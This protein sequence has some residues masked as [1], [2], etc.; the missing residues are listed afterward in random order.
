MADRPRLPVFN[1][2]V[3]FGEVGSGMGLEMDIELLKFGPDEPCSVVVCKG[4]T[5]GPDIESGARP[6]VPA[7]D[8][9]SALVS[10]FLPVGVEVWPAELI[11]WLLS[12]LC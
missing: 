3:G 10:I 11:I 6:G 12:L 7:A 4:W 9:E 1:S 5:T 2:W 8:S